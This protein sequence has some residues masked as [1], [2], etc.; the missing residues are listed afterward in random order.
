MILIYS[1]M[2]Q[3][4]SSI[5]NQFIK[6][7]FFLWSIPSFDPF[8]FNMSF[9][10]ETHFLQVFIYILSWIDTNSSSTTWCNPFEYFFLKGTGDTNNSNSNNNNNIQTYPNCFLLSINKFI[11]QKLKTFWIKIIRT[12]KK[13]ETQSLVFKK[14]LNKF[15]PTR[16]Q[17]CVNSDLTF[18]I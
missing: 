8:S 13:T 5:N 18:K 17:Q 2:F 14:D 7:T 10:H 16:A 11:L 12:K 4:I 9:S 15:T 6:H 1:N 3:D